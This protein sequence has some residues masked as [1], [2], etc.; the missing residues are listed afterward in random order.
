M[1]IFGHRGA[2]A[3]LP[4]NTLEAFRRALELGVDVIE[5]DVH[6]T[7]DGHVVVHHDATGARTSNEPR[8]VADVTLDELRRWDAGRGFR[9]TLATA[10]AGRRFQVPTLEE[11]LE[12][13]PGVPLN[14]DIKPRGAV[15]L[16]LRVIERAGAHERV[17]LT[18]FH[19]DV[20]RAVRAAGY[21]GRT[22]LSRGEV[23]RALA[24]PA[25][26]PKALRPPGDRVQIPVAMGPVPLARSGLVR[27]LQRLDLR[28]DFWVVND[29][30]GA[31]RVVQSGA[32]GIMTDDPR[33]IVSAIRGR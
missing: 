21:K 23:L 14:V 19:D 30:V 18:S 2:S 26:A 11:A 3:E 5:T 9:G 8:A 1:L 24:L 33:T 16:V 6:V 25:W 32:D 28:V 4:E 13:L 17:L 12:A 27:R 22:G 10:D 31:H 29:V 20:T 7:R 15:P